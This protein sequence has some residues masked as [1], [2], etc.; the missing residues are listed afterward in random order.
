MQQTKDKTEFTY[1]IA[2]TS[3]YQYKSTEELTDEQV[4]EDTGNWEFVE[5]S[6][7]VE[8]KSRILNLR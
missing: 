1:F 3:Y 6:S 8:C 5:I 2:S 4:L 7:E